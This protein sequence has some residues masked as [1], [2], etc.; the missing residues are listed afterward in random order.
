MATKGLEYEA[1]AQVAD[2]LRDG[3]TS[4]CDDDDNVVSSLL[5]I[6]NAIRYAADRLGTGDASTGGWG[7]L[8]A[9]G[10]VMEQGF[11]RLAGSIDELSAAVENQ[12][13]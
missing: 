9:L 12:K 7:A 6:A 3:M 10:K 4:D 1:V 8:E 13:K 2:A 5:A 11:E